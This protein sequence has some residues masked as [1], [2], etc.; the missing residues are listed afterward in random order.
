MFYY[1]INIAFAWVMVGAFYLIFAIITRFAF[2]DPDQHTE[3]TG[4][5]NIVTNIYIILLAVVF[6]LSLGVKPAQAEK[7]YLF[8]S[9]FFAIYMIIIFA[10][11]VNFSIASGDDSVILYIFALTIGIFS[12]SCVLYGCCLDVLSGLI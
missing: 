6:V 2:P 3:L 1:G 5:G 8:I 12:F 11:M 10:F 7:M 4:I 9:S